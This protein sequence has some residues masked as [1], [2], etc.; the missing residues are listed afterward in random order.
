MVDSP[1]PPH[2]T[3]LFPNIARKCFWMD[4][5]LHHWEH[6]GYFLDIILFSIYWYNILIPQADNSLPCF[7]FRFTAMAG[8]HA[9]S[10]TWCIPA[11]GL[12][13]NLQLLLLCQ[14]PKFRLYC[15]SFDRHRGHDDSRTIE[16]GIGSEHRFFLMKQDA[17]VI[18]YLLQI[19]CCGQF[20]PFWTLFS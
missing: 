6:T 12:L 1:P 9:E 3:I 4:L 15:Q 11:V 14:L 19:F 7:S 2:V 13:H 16:L 8:S 17:N 10:L 18:K 20:F 5:E